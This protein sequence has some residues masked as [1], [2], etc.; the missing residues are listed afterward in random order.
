[1]INIIFICET[2][3]VK[4][5]SP[6][7]VCEYLSGVSLILLFL[8]F[9]LIK[10]V[11]HVEWQDNSICFFP[12]LSHVVGLYMWTNPSGSVC[13]LGERGCSK[14]SGQGERPPGEGE[15]GSETAD[16]GGHG[17]HRDAALPARPQ[18]EPHQGAG[19]WTCH[20]ETE[21]QAWGGL[22]K[23]KDALRMRQWNL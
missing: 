3:T 15:V 23:Q 4:S 10:L 1:M 20:G 19:G 16:Q 11:K 8:L 13:L 17:A 18:G 7:S 21:E 6:Y 22:F 2:L 14:G 12:P 9:C 5:V